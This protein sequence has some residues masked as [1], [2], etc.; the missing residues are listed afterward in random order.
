M[1]AL[2]LAYLPAISRVCTM[3]NACSLLYAAVLT[4][5]RSFTVENDS[6]VSAFFEVSMSSLLFYCGY[7]VSIDGG[8]LTVAAKLVIAILSFMYARFLYNMHVVGIP[9]KR[10]D[11]TGISSSAYTY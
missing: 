9:Y 11:L 6:A 3:L 8:T 2:L 5:F 1:N 7:A 10:I 4:V